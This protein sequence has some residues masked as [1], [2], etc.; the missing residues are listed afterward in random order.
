MFV[1]LM[2]MVRSASANEIQTAFGVGHFN[3]P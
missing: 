1:I 2:M 3:S